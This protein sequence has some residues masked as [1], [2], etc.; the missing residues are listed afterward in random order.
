MDLIVKEQKIALQII[1]Y[2]D[3]R[4]NR[5]F[6]SL[7]KIIKHQINY[8]LSHYIVQ[9]HGFDKKKGV[10]LFEID[11]ENLSFK[12]NSSKKHSIDLML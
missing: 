4:E 2:L 12:V 6:I 3:D 10:M 5:I 8:Y 9:N 11:E 1:D 7:S